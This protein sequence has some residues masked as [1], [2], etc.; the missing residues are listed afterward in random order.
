MFINRYS[1]IL[2]C[3]SN[4]RQGSSQRR[5]ERKTELWDSK[6]RGG[7]VQP[8]RKRHLPTLSSSADGGP[9]GDPALVLG[10][11]SLGCVCVSV[12]SIHNN[13]CLC[14]HL[15]CWSLLG[16]AAVWRCPWRLWVGSSETD[17]NTV[18]SH[19]MLGIHS[20]ALLGADG[21]MLHPHQKCSVR[22]QRRS[23]WL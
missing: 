3:I 16:S 13:I 23:R 4:R 11:E 9:R 14:L 15:P 12:S 5:R 21:P 10:Q 20:S 2:A 22:M 19:Q 18:S 1:S 7:N 6:F 8:G 17:C